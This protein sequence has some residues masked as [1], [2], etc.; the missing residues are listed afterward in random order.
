MAPARMFVAVAS[1]FACICSASS[2]LPAATIEH[3]FHEEVRGLAGKGEVN[4]ELPAIRKTL[5][6]MWLELP[7]TSE[8]RL[9]SPEVMAALDRYF[10]ERHG[11]ELK[12][13]D[14]EVASV[15]VG[16]EVPVEQ[17]PVYLLN[18]FE[19]IFGNEGLMLHEVALF[20]ST[21][22]KLIQEHPSWVAEEGSPKAEDGLD[23]PL[24][25]ESLAANVGTMAV[26]VAAVLCIVGGSKVFE[27]MRT[28]KHAA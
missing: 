1:S 5:E 12:G 22:E 17:V 28:K 4:L 3:R 18:L 14:A 2:V 16:G 13:L 7:R 8:N 11:L 15:E 27:S 23:L 10:Q 26:A 6:P 24:Q 9:A 20:A 21:L 19:E 25:E